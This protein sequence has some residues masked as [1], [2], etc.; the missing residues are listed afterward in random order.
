MMI[1]NRQ[2]SVLY[3]ISGQILLG[4]VHLLSEG[5]DYF[6]RHLQIITDSPNI[7]INLPV[8]LFVS[9]DRDTS[10]VTVSMAPFGTLFGVLPSVSTLTLMPEQILHMIPTP[11]DLLDRYLDAMSIDN[12]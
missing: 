3:L 11:Q 1:P 9:P 5:E 10:S 6:H 4:Y 7:H 12:S 2:H 8:E